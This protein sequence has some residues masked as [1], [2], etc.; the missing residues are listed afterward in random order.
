MAATALCCLSGC[1]EE[2]RRGGSEPQQTNA[3][4]AQSSA[5]PSTAQTSATW[6]FFN[7]I[8]IGSSAQP[9]TAQTSAASVQD[10]TQPT[11]VQTNAAAAQDTTQPDA[12]SIVTGTGRDFGGSRGFGS[13]EEACEASLI[14]RCS[15]ETNIDKVF[16]MVP[17]GFIRYLINRY[18][19]T[20][21]QIKKTVADKYS[22]LEPASYRNF[23]ITEVTEMTDYSR[24]NDYL[25]ERGISRGDQFYRLS[26]TYEMVYNDGSTKNGD[27]EF[28]VY[29]VNGRW[30][31]YIA[32]GLIEKPLKKK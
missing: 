31:P 19:M 11:N 32:L 1:G 2:I 12:S 17:E 28:N 4:N 26:A 20:E 5:Q 7:F 10:Y 29:Q 21:E 30:Y 13:K 22:S 27:E 14:A 23:V 9:S 6:T 24:Y 18:N 15:L 25:G 16:D 3:G 8:P